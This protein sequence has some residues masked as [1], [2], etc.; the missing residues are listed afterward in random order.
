MGEVKL[1]DIILALILVPI[2]LITLPFVWVA[3]QAQLIF[4]LTATLVSS[5]LLSLRNQNPK[6]QDDELK[7]Q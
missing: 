7:F 4:G 6:T 1:V 5:R 3:F 2:I